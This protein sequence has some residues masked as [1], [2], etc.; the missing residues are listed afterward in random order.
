MNASVIAVCSSREHHFSKTPRD[1]IRLIADI[2]VEGD[3]HSGSL[4]R[5]RSRVRRNPL[6]PNLRQVH[7]IGSELFDEVRQ[8]GFT[9][10]PGE[11]GE[12][13][14]TAGIDLINLP[15]GTRLRLGRDAVVQITG[16]RNPCLQID[17]F[18]PGLLA[19]V[20]EK[21]ENGTITRKAGIMSIVI[22]TGVVRPGDPIEVTL[23]PEPHVSLDRV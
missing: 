21:D 22:A 3:A 19:Q 2:G 20:A 10:S 5:H 9:V 12:N 1:E 11:M 6:Q 15:K 23:P 16:L 8:A 18:Q 17:E 4:V 7:L 13:V 14:T